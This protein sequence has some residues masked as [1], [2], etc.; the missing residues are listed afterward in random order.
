MRSRGRH[1]EAKRT[2]L[3][4]FLHF[5]RG[6]IRSEPRGER[7]GWEFF[8]FFR[9]R[10]GGV[11][12]AAA[13]MAAAGL[14]ILMEVTRR[15]QALS[16]TPMLLAV[17]PFPS[18]LTTP[19][20]T[21]TYFMVSSPRLG[22]VPAPSARSPLSRARVARSLTAAAR[23]RGRRGFPGLSPWDRG[24]RGRGERRL[25]GPAEA[26]VG[27]GR[28]FYWGARGGLGLWECGGGWVK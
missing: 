15:P 21:S 23:A 4:P 13:A 12:T 9:K 18:P 3:L 1:Y 7:G 20:V 17:T 19:P 24:G 26:E 5:D 27:D 28:F 22:R 8:F 14:P 10:T 25:A 11:G 2:L 6:E 16:R